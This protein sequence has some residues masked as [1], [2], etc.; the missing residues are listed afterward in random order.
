MMQRLNLREQQ[1]RTHYILPTQESAISKAILDPL[2]T[3][4]TYKLPSF[5]REVVEKFS[6]ALINIVPIE[7]PAPHPGVAIEKHAMPWLMRVRHKKMKKH[8]LKKFRKNNIFLHRKLAQAKRQKK[9]ALMVNYEKRM[10][11][12]ASAFDAEEYISSRIEKAKRGGWGIDPLL[13]AKEAQTQSPQ[14]QQ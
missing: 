10:S 8:K 2:C 12:F 11:A 9:E 4:V 3:N 1:Q 6:P 7:D 5:S 14:T 13:T